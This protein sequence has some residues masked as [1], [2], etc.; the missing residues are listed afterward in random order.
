MVRWHLIKN[1][2][3]HEQA[4]PLRKI[5]DDLIR[6]QNCDP[7][8]LL[9]SYQQ[10]LQG[11]LLNP[12]YPDE[13]QELLNSGL[14]VNKD[15]ELTVHNPIYEAIFDSSWVAKELNSLRPYAKELV[16]WLN[17]GCRD[18]STLLRG[19][20]LQDSLASIK[21]QSLREEEERF[22]IASQVVNLRAI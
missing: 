8:W 14:V 12:N 4:T 19:Q 20:V 15:G 11:A 3:T 1:W 13:Q 17:S 10:I 7:F 21:G 5:R 16:A 6:N 18:E 2:E 22:L 9:F